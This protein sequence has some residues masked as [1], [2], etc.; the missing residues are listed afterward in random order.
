M[1]ILPFNLI[2]GANRRKACCSYRIVL[3]WLI[4]LDLVDACLV[5]SAP[6]G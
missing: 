4:F 3:K 2:R 1:Y 5:I 6:N